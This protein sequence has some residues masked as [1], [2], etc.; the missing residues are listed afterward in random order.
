[1]R[2]Y[3]TL[4][5][6]L[7]DDPELSRRGKFYSTRLAIWDGDTCTNF[8]IED[9]R[10]VDINN[11]D[12]QQAV[13]KFIAGRDVWEKFREAEPPPGFHDLSAMIDRGHLKIEGDV[14][15]WLFNMLYIKRL[16]SVW[17]ANA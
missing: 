9:G 7:N 6:N 13:F 14:R 8:E 5:E 11:E 4:I 17:K 15:P 12:N 2:S 3:Q 10:V 1:M 16:I